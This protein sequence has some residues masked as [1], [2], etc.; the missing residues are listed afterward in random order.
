MSGGPTELGVAATPAVVDTEMRAT[1][2]GGGER[3]GEEGG[4]E[5]WP[6]EGLRSPVA[7]FAVRLPALYGRF[8]VSSFPFARANAEW[9]ALLG[10]VHAA[11]AALSGAAAPP[12]TPAVTAGSLTY[13]LSGANG[14]HAGVA[15]PAISLAVGQL[16][17]ADTVA[18]DAVLEEDLWV[19]V[20]LAGLSESRRLCTRRRKPS[21]GEG[22]E[23]ATLDFGYSTELAIAPGSEEQAAL[24]EALSSAD[25]QDA[26]V[27][28][29][30]MSRREAGPRGPAGATP[31]E[32][33]ELVPKVQLAQGYLNLRQMLRDGC[34]LRSS[35]LSLQGRR[36]AG[37]LGTLDVS[38]SAIEAIRAHQAHYL[39][40]R[41]GEAENA[42]P[43]GAGSDCTS[44]RAEAA[45]EAAE[46]VCAADSDSDRA[47][48]RPR[49][50]RRKGLAAEEA[51]APEPEPEVAELTGETHPKRVY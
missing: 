9:R 48:R 17:L 6:E 44:A 5:A 10:Q 12:T 11:E 3:S 49:R 37:C 33:D 23:G 4:A 21:R 2:P 32:K 29:G 36:G 1:E 28:F 35:R 39:Y 22:E 34:D 30:L 20:D 45:V 16:S 41:G 47:R 24:C 46:E 50:R 13:A 40:V 51:A 42:T 18:D 14:V 38:L 7:S 27:Y 31:F 15:C 25:E 43:A 8:E 19:E 26:D